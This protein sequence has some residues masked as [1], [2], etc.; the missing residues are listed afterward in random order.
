M[1]SHN[2]FLKTSNPLN[3]NKNNKKKTES[4]NKNK[5]YNVININN[6]NNN[7]NNNNSN[8][9]AIYECN[10][11]DKIISLD[12]NYIIQENYFEEE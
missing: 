1:P 3:F 4:K 11:Q 9:N 7:N 10:N 2:R 6:N 12:K 5:N 8:N